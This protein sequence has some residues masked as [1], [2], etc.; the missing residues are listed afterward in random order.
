MPIWKE[1]MTHHAIL[2]NDKY[3]DISDRDNAI[4]DSVND[5]VIIN[6]DNDNANLDSANDT[7][8]RYKDI[9]D[10]NNDDTN[11]SGKAKTESV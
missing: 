6:C 3:S 8:D 9:A 4:L 11:D 5:N 1:T 7:L 10:S 2:E